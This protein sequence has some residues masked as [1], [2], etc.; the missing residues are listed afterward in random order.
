MNSAIGSLCE[1]ESSRRYSCC[2]KIINTN[3]YQI[4]GFYSLGV[5]RVLNGA[6][7]YFYRVCVNQRRFRTRV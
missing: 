4:N 2:N 6:F 3:S 5:L 1:L 7:I